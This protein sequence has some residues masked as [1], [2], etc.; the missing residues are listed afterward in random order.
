MGPAPILVNP[1]TTA[2]PAPVQLTQKQ[3]ERL[4]KQEQR[5]L[6]KLERELKKEEEKKLKQEERERKERERQA[7]RELLE[8]EKE[9]KR[10]E[11]RVRKE[12]KRK[13]LDEEKKRKDEE[14]KRKEDEK[15]QRDEDKKRKE[16]QKDR[17]QMRISSF[18]AVKP[19]KNA[20]GTASPAEESVAVVKEEKLLYTQQFLPFFIKLNV[21]MAPTGMLLPEQLESAIS[22]FDSA[23]GKGQKLTLNTLLPPRSTPSP[24]TFTSSL[25]LLEALNTNTKEKQLVELAENLPPIKYLQFYENSKPPYIGTWCSA[26]HLATGI[27]A[28]NPLETTLTGYDYNYDSDLD[29]DGDDDEG[30]DID[31]LEDGDD[32]DDD[33]N[34]DDDDMDDFVDNNEVAKRKLPVGAIQSVSRWNYGTPEDL[35]HFDDI[36]YERLD[37]DIHL[38]IDP[39]HDYWGS[40]KV[41]VSVRKDKKAGEA[42][43]PVKDTTRA[44]GTPGSTTPTTTNVLTP[45]KP[46]I[47]D[48]KVVA[49][50]I[51]F[52]EKNS[53]FT[54]GTLLELAKKEFKTYTK[55]MLKYTIQDV[56]IYNKKKSMWEIKESRR[57]AQSESGCL[58]VC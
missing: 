31:D 4:K 9:R 7:K 5:E 58:G 53:D 19:P 20:L 28:T 6:E 18:F 49:E 56:A 22:A 44:T 51:K 34:N 38:P 36:K 57:N 40:A 39:F 3:L 1:A 8:K 55:S 42:T 54:I 10:E 37:F 17:N 47:K 52:V 46:A 26:Q 33:A 50:L 13:K 11:E 24:N 30:E 27:G 45:Q 23:L 21:I 29:W 2:S 43:T 25:Q 32:D 15:K 12:E 48:A 35:A 14:K 41:L 16:Q